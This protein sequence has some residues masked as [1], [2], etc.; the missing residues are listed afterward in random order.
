MYTIWVYVYNDTMTLNVYMYGGKD[1]WGYMTM[2][3][4]TLL[5]QYENTIY[6]VLP[7]KVTHVISKQ[8]DAVLISILQNNLTK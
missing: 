8:L 6:R 4:Y 5:K 7:K 2:W 3:G 1:V